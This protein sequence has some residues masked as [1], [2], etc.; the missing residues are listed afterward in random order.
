MLMLHFPSPSLPVSDGAR[1]VGGADEIDEIE[2][3]KAVGEDGVREVGGAGGEANGASVG[4]EPHH[5]N[6]S[7]Q[8]AK[9][10]LYSE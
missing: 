6:R 4:E 3:G 9:T 10:T 1:E 8:V 2:G 5:N 7:K